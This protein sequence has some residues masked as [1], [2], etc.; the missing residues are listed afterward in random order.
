MD[1]ILQGIGVLGFVIF[2]FWGVAAIIIDK[3]KK[4]PAIGIVISTVILLISAAMPEAPSS[5]VNSI[6]NES[7]VI[8]EKK[9]KDELKKVIENNITGMDRGKYFLIEIKKNKSAGYSVIV[10][11]RAYSSNLCTNVAENIIRGL[12]KY[13]PAAFKKIDNITF[14]FVDNNDS[15]LKVTIEVKDTKAVTKQEYIRNN[16]ILKD[17]KGKD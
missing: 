15:S 7:Q 13:N 11:L 17:S 4:L 6:N 9:D 8:S 16:F 3:S 1:R 12:M 10:Q 2:F 14:K 5:K